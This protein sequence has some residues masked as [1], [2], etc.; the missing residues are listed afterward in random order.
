MNVASTNT[1]YLV[2]VGLLGVQYMP[3]ASTL[4]NMGFV[5]SF[6]FN[7]FS[8]ECDRWIGYLLR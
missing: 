3:P 8:V 6:V 1:A 7:R 2:A 5:Y 4:E